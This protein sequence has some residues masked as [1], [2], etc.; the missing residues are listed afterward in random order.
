MR[1]YLP[2]LAAAAMTALTATA[3]ADTVNMTGGYFYN[4]GNGYSPVS[5][6]VDPAGSSNAKNFS[7]TNAGGLVG[8]LSGTNTLFWC[9]DLYSNLRTGD[10]TYNVSVVTAG[11]PL[12]P[13]SSTSNGTNWTMTPTA[14]TANQLNA[15]LSN[16]QTFVAGQSGTS[17][18]AASA[19]LQVAIW[20][21]LYNGN[22][23]AVNTALSGSN[24][25]TMTTTGTVLTDANAFMQCIAGVAQS[26]FCATGG[27]SA[28][29]NKEVRS[30][31]FTSQGTTTDGQ[32]FLTL[33]TKSPD[34][35]KV[36]EPASLA[37]LGAGLAGL[38]LFRRRR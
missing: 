35:P 27:W 7:N 38:G 29:A 22:T 3:Q 37:L 1:R 24:F 12:Y 11:T 28:D 21:L 13:N 16:G 5:G 9:E 10:A 4:S 32:S 15:L 25:F 8:V 26:G 23:N 19:A 17:Q 30:Y 33:V 18:N 2:V 20:A 6:T 31:A 14:T 34:T 36:P